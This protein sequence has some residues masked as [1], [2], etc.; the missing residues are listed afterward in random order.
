[1]QSFS[2]PRN[3]GSRPARSTESHSAEDH[4]SNAGSSNSHGHR[5][6]RK[7]KSFMNPL[8]VIRRARSKV[9]LDSEDRETQTTHKPPPFL[10]TFVSSSS[11][12]SSFLHMDPSKT[13]L[14]AVRGRDKKKSKSGAVPTDSS[15]VPPE[16]DLDL[17]RMEGIIDPSRLPSLSHSPPI[18]GFA[19]PSGSRFSFE[20]RAPTPSSSSSSPP[21]LGGPV[22]SDPFISR[23]PSVR[24][25]DSTQDHRR[26][27]PRTIVPAAAVPPY[28]ISTSGPQDA[29]WTAPPSWVSGDQPE[30]DVSSSEDEKAPSSKRKSRR[31]ATIIRTLQSQGV[32]SRNYKIRVYRTNTEYHILTC[33]LATT[34]AQLSGVLNT[35]IH[36][37]E[38][39][40]D[41]RLY[42]KER[43]RGSSHRLVSF[44]SS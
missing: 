20:G 35:I 33:S 19:E 18:S 1:M 16:F 2:P 7:P 26:M 12:D 4:A 41:H 13:A 27:S 37:L 14:R 15:V 6:L 10:P 31:R 22:F 43:G 17:R 23:P 40:E 24:S 42:L 34:V 30:P 3:Q 9:R 11:G 21:K 39:R 38:E 28:L 25:R 32:E 36:G 29:A 8:N 44:R 5:E